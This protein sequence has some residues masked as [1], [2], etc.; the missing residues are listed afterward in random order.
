MGDPV[1]TNQVTMD[2]SLLQY[3]EIVNQSPVIEIMKQFPR[4]LEM[5]EEELGTSNRI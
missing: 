3:K 5:T 4:A 1:L 2:S